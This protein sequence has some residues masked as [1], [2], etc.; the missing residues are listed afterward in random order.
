MKR[1]IIQFAPFLIGAHCG[2]TI[3]LQI[4]KG[5]MGGTHA[6]LRNV[7]IIENSFD[8]LSIVGYALIGAGLAGFLCSIGKSAFGNDFDF[9]PIKERTYLWEKSVV[10]LPLVSV[11]A[12]VMMSGHW[13]S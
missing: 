6:F 10:T 3:W 4:E 11:G 5:K 12:L 13:L 1:Q 2:L 9:D 7:R 8:L